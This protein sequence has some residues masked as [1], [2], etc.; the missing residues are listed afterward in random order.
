MA[1]KHGLDYA[2]SKESNKS[3]VGVSYA[4]IIERDSRFATGGS[5]GADAHG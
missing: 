3:D 1:L 5:R 2:T 4:S